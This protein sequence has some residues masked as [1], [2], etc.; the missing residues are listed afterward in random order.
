MAGGAVKKPVNIFKLRNLDEPSQVFNWRLWFAVISF[1][2]L[3]AARGVDEGLISGAFNSKNFQSSI[4]YSSYTKSEQANIKANVSAMV[5]IGSVAGALLAFVVCDRIGRIWATRQLCVLWV[6]GIAIFMGAHGNLGAIYAGRFIAGLGVGQTPVVGPVY[7]AEIAP[8]SIRG[9]CT[10]IFT[11]FVYLGIVLA[12]FTNYGSQLHLGDATP[13]RWL[14]PTSLHVMFAGLIFVLT[15]LQCESPRYLVKQGQDERA[16]RVMARLR[17]LPPDH[18]YVV[19]EMGAITRS[20]HEEIETTRGA[21]WLGIL[22]EAFTIRSNLYRVGLTIG[23]QVMSQ[24][25]GAGSITLYAPD[26]FALLGVTG[27]D[28]TLLVT[29]VFGVVKLVAAVLCALFLV[30]FI[31]RK[32]SLLLGIGFQAV[33]MVYVAGFLT[34]VPGLGGDTTDNSY[35]LSAAELGPSKGAIAM[36]Y[37]SGFGWALGWNS[38]QYLLTAELFPLRIRAFCTSLAM[39]FHFANQYGNSR[40][41]PNMLLP[42]ADGGISAQGTFWCFAAVTL[43]GAAWVW[44]F[45]PET[46][47]RSLESMD[48]LFSLPWYQIGRYGNRDADAQDRAA[49]D[50]VHHL[51]K[52]RS[53]ASNESNESNDSSSKAAV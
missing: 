18:A 22:R 45:I 26:L 24:W 17:N 36:I 12:Y 2:L 11:G 33:A 9:F 37:L 3:G 27:T 5:Q 39:T 34:A 50:S 20:H 10:C 38:M 44:F 4:G 48:R 30:D 52:D 46:A 15:F 14:V 51:E 21:G 42:V 8:A 32:R 47:G 49:F 29:A 35:T 16:L 28:E 1:G 25:S 19:G 53:N 23:A 7:I 31:G 41:V 13:N 40:A 43:L 6:V